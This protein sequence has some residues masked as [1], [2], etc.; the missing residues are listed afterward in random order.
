[1]FEKEVE[2]RRQRMDSGFDDNGE[3][4]HR[5]KEKRNTKEGTIDRLK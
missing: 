3:E 4:R 1:M 2:R 5:K